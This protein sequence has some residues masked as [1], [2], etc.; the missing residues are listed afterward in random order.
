MSTCKLFTTPCYGLR[1]K[2]IGKI[3]L[4]LK[5]TIKRSITF[6]ELREKEQRSKVYTAI[7]VLYFAFLFFQKTASL[8]EYLVEEQNTNI[9]IM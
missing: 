9:S 1:E 7:F 4:S 3:F 8:W 2:I 5:L 6:N